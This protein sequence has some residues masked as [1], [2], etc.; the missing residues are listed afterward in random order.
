[1]RNN[2]CP[3]ILWMQLCVVHPLDHPAREPGDT[4]LL[5][6]NRF[7]DP[8]EGS[9]LDAERKEEYRQAERVGFDGIMTNEHHIGPFCMQ[10]R[11]NITSAIL[12]GITD[13][14]KIVQLGNPIPVWENR[15]QLAEE[16]VTIDMMS[17]GRLVAGIVRGGGQ[18]QFANNVN[19]AFNR[20]RFEE[21][22][23]SADQSLD[24]ART[25]PMGR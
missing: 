25:V 5:F 12:A 20:E 22:R 9:R 11:C 7:F 18:E 17:G 10:P 2:R 8:S 23:L 13:R 19:P 14:V 21:G 6:S 15:V 16:T 3:H 4:V 24:R 1:M